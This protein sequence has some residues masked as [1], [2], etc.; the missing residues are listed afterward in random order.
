MANVTIKPGFDRRIYTA[1]ALIQDLAFLLSS[2]FNIRRAFR[3][4]NISRAFIEKIM[5]II[6]AVNGCV[7]CA[8]F[9]ARQALESGL[10]EAEVS[11][12]LKLQ[13]QAD[14]SD[15]EIMALLYAQH[16]AESDRDPDPE[17]TQKLFE[18][19]G[20]DTARHILL[21]I[22]M[23]SFGNLY[24][25]TWDAVLSRFKGAPAPGSSLLFELVFF[26]LN[27]PV[28]LPTSLIIRNQE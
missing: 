7:Y 14:A 16:Y 15:D 13:F 27:V 26:L 19:Y 25:N 17:M 10:S 6:T 4:E 28:M 8:W 2:T 11:N 5:A 12:L 3:D 20:R 24:G 22:R 1:S 9:H 18:V 23:I 21:F